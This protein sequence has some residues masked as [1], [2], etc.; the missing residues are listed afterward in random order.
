MRGEEKAS[1]VLMKRFFARSS[2]R[3]IGRRI[4]KREEILNLRKTRMPA[5]HCAPFY[6]LRVFLQSFTPFI[7]ISKY[8]FLNIDFQLLPFLNINGAFLSRVLIS[9]ILNG[10]IFNSA[11][12]YN[13]HHF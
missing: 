8:T 4:K 13:Y 11:L 7:Y 5:C 3:Y 12:D 6:Q 10:N 9:P 2:E 1:N